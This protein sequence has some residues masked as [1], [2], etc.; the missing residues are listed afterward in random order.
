MPAFHYYPHLPNQDDPPLFSE[1]VPNAPPEVPRDA[2]IWP[3]S[4]TSASRLSM[5]RWIP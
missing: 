2:F 1:A 3:E 5:T 4:S